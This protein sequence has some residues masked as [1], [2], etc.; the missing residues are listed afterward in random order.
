MLP[1]IQQTDL[2]MESEENKMKTPINI[3]K[4]THNEFNNLKSG[5]IVFVKCGDLTFQ[6]TVVQPPFYNYDSDEPDWEVETTNGFC[7][8]YSLYIYA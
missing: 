4:I 5:D 6:S 3:R 7:D 1:Y 2:I 8:E